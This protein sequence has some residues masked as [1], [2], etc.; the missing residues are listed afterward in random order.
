MTARHDAPRPDP[1]QPG[2]P[3]SGVPQSG[4]PQSGAPQSGAP[5]PGAPW[6]G[7][8][9][10]GAPDGVRS[11]IRSDRD[12]V[13][14]E[15]LPL[16]NAAGGRADEHGDVAFYLRLVAGAARPVVELGVGYGRVARWTRPDYGVDESVQMLRSCADRAPGMT[17]VDARL[18][19]YALAE[20]AALSYAPQNLLSLLGSPDEVMDALAGVRR[21]TRPGGKFAF[22]VAVP[23]WSRIRSRLDRQLAHGQVGPLLLSYRAELVGIDPGGQQGSLLMHHVVERLDP[24]GAVC[25]RI[26]YPPVPVDYFTPRRWGEMLARAG[27]QVQECWGGL[28]GEPLTA[29][30][31]QQVWLVHR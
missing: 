18:Q 3:Q 17:L 26:Q 22:D 19:D 2:A 29:R 20:P 8:P 28:C 24:A 31:R 11:H 16:W 23:D 14:H 30:S 21:N 27:W 5:R 15:V 12:A 1:P 6:L 9:R 7:A 13:W 25:A 10:P 4:V